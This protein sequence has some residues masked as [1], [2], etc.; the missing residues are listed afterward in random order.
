[1]AEAAKCLPFN[2]PDALTGQPE[3][4]AH[5]FQRVA[6]AILQTK[7]QPQ[8]P[9]LTRGQGCQDFFYFFT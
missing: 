8:N 7:S 3:L 4:L 9:R 5:F 2:L 1:M 6:A